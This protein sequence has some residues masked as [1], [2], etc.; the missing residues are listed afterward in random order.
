MPAWKDKLEN[1]EVLIID[2]AMGTELERRGVPMHAETWSGAAVLEHPEAIVAAHEDYIRAGAEVIITN[3]FGASPHMLNAMGYGDRDEE[4]IRSAVDLAKQARDNIGVD[5][6]IA[7]SISTMSAGSDIA[8]PGDRHTD[9]E[10]DDSMSRMARA[11]A[12]GG[13]D[14]IALEMMQDVRRAP[15][16][17]RGA[18]ATGLPVWL[19][20]TCAW[21]EGW[22]KLV[23]FDFPDY[24]FDDILDALIPIGPDVVS[25]MHSDMD[26]TTKALEVVKQRWSGPLGAYPESGYFEMPNWRFVDVIAPGDFVERARGWVGQGVTILGGCCGL[27]PV[28]VAAMHEALPTFH[29]H[30]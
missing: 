25:V 1:G 5:V 29:Q 20:L 12:A 6:A 23:A 17:M 14:M 10:I 7:G 24:A 21:N 15:A 28:H 11:L 16:A 22:D 9:E 30:A 13:C 18:K 2:G 19:G 4:I 3:T 27:G 26:V 8:D